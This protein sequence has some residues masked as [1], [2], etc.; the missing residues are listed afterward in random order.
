MYFMTGVL[1]YYRRPVE[2]IMQGHVSDRTDTFSFGI[3]VIELMT[4]TTP[5]QARMV[6]ED[7][8]DFNVGAAL[9]QHSDALELGFPN[10]VK[11]VMGDVVE[12]CTMSKHRMRSTLA[13]ELPKLEQALA[14]TLLAL[15]GDAARAGCAVTA[16]AV[17]NHSPPP[18]V[19]AR[20][21][22]QQ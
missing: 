16:A 21:Q 13:A 2:Y 18:Q 19:Q 10:D 3:L 9:A 20:Q 11:S 5:L 4:F 8:A 14:L 22:Q 17:P 1:L 7:L 12:R 6:I 15:M